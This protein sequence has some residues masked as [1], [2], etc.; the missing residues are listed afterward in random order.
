MKP[1]RALALKITLVTVLSLIIVSYGLFQA[2]NLI[3]GPRIIL[4]TPQNGEN[5]LN[6]L[7]IVSG[8][9]VNITYISLNDRQIF[10]DD[11]GNF[12]EKLLVPPG[13]TIIKLEA[14]DKFGRTT[15]K[16]IELNYTTST[17]TQG[18]N[19]QKIIQ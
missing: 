7:V 15:T 18:I 6:P 11:Q 17:S 13:Y 2:R 12:S 8:S 16:L 1:S 19:T 3:I 9:A 4:S 5:V 10:V 14:R